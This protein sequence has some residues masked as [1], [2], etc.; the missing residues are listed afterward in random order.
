MVIKPDQIN[1]KKKAFK[2]I[3]RIIDAVDNVEE[4]FDEVYNGI[5]NVYWDEMPSYVPDPNSIRI[6]LNRLVNKINNLRTFVDNHPEKF[7]P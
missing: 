1:T 4:V 3:D 2:Y 6:Q 7:K 5:L